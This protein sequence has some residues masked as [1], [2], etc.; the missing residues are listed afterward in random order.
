VRQAHR[1]D[2]LFAVI[3]YGKLGG[4]ELGYA[5]DLDLVFL[6]DDD[7]AEAGENYA[8]LAQRM[9]YWLTTI[10][11]AGVLYEIDLRLRPDGAGGL[12]V[13]P[14]ES[15]CEYQSR[16]AWI[17]EQQA[18]SRAR[19]VAGDAAIGKKFEELRVAVLRQPRDAAALRRE[20]AAM[21]RKLLAGHPNRTAL[22]DLKHD[23][24]GLIDVEFVVQYLVLCH[25]HRHPELTGNLGNLALLKLAAR[26]ALID[27]GRASAVHDAY[28]RFRRLQHNLRLQGE[29]YARVA[30][31]TVA[32]ERQ[33][34]R[35]LW[36]S[37]I[38]DEGE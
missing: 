18:L 15:F 7:A 38:G 4:K 27:E 22:F 20:V 37:V 9:S 32:A 16:H 10:T 26:L 13:S 25:A 19:H 3:G 5:S 34:V 36:D 24:G 1:A 21:R 35:E 6:Y 2:A 12:L 8:R 23:P 31:E 11:A 30:P 29:R 14:L 28:R 33:V 17:W